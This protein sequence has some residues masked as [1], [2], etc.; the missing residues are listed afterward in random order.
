MSVVWKVDDGAD[1]QLE[2]NEHNEYYFY[3]NSDTTIG[4]EPEDLLDLAFTI[5]ERLG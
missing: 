3:L 5:Y 4:V 1:L 2:C